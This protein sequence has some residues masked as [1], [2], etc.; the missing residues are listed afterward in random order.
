MPLLGET[1]IVSI[2]AQLWSLEPGRYL[3]PHGSCDKRGARALRDDL[4]TEMG[5]KAVR[6]G[7]DGVEMQWA[8]R[9]RGEENIEEDSGGDKREERTN[10]AAH[11]RALDSAMAKA[12]ALPRAHTEETPLLTEEPAVDGRDSNG[13][14]GVVIGGGMWVIDA[15]EDPAEMSRGGDANGDLENGGGED[16]SIGGEEVERTAARGMLVWRGMARVLMVLW[17]RIGGAVRWAAHIRVPFLSGRRRRETETK[18]A[19]EGENTVRTGGV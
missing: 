1:K 12:A 10:D 8:G 2:L 18:R 5:I 9:E 4:L 6:D 13:H 7:R 11:M 3:P 15:D 16:E 19:E 17:A 14:C